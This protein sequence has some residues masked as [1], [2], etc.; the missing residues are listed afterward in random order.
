MKE[1][2]SQIVEL[3]K[4]GKDF[5]YPYSQYEDLA[6][7]IVE[8]YRDEAFKKAQIAHLILEASIFQEAEDTEGYK[9]KIGQALEY[10][11]GMHWEDIEDE[12]ILAK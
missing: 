5:K 6:I 3:I 9:E 7:G 12:I 4:G 1:L 10:A 11:C 8:Q 2:R